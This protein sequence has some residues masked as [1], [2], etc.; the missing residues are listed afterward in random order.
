MNLSKYILIVMVLAVTALGMVSTV[1]AQTGPILK[2]S[3]V[4]YDP[5]PANPGDT[6]DIWVRMENE[7]DT[8]ANNVAVQFVDS[9]PFKLSTETDREVYVPKISS[10]SEYLVKYRVIVDTNAPEGSN[11]ILLKSTVGTDAKIES[12]SKVAIDIRTTETPISVTKVSVKPETIA[13][14]SKAKVDR[15][16]VV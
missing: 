10:G 14:G 7:G 13:P 12:T 2:A 3:L 6:V 9:F 11:S 4:N 16:S 8:D 1:S 15:K 5:A